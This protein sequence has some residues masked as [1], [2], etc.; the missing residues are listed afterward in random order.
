MA[1]FIIRGIAQP[2]RINVKI[3]GRFRDIELH[4][5][6]DEILDKLYA[7]KCPYVEL[8]PEEFIKQQG[9]DTIKV[10]PLKINKPKGK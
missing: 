10:K 3:D 9:L 7:D 6:P 4:N 8:S 2:G 5:V 1:K